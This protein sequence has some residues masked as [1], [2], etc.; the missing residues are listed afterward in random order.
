MALSEQLN[1]RIN[2][3]GWNYKTVS[4]RTGVKYQ[5]VLRLVKGE[6]KDPRMSTLAK[7]ADGLGV[8]VDYLLDREEADK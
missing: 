1:N 7:L 3:L 4:E 6:R 2:E 8:S 5:E